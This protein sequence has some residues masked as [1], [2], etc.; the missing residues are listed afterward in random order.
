MEREN[1]S[2]LAGFESR[3]VQT[4]VTKPAMRKRCKVNS[5]ITFQVKL[6]LVHVIRACRKLKVPST[7][8]MP[9]VKIISRQW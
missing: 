6:V 3:L 5:N 9:V 4:A 7:T 1:P 2:P 8:T